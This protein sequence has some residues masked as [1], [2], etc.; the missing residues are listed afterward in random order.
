[1]CRHSLVAGGTKSMHETEGET[2]EHEYECCDGVAGG[3]TS[4]CLSA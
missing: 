1:M 4:E 2:S 3:A